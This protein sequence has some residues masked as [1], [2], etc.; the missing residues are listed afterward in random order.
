MQCKHNLG[1]PGSRH[2]PS[3]ISRKRKHDAHSE[4]G[5]SANSSV[6]A[7][8]TTSDY[9]SS[10]WQKVD[11]LGVSDFRQ[12]FFKFNDEEGNL[13]LIKHYDKEDLLLIY[14]YCT[15]ESRYES[16]DTRHRF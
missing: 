12:L 8:A 3:E 7:K 6:R 2:P 10:K 16:L 14:E 11:D 9:F 5:K 15:G 1:T 4:G 13:N